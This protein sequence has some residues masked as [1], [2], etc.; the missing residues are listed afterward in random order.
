MALSATDSPFR[1]LH[2]PRELRDNVYEEIAAESDLRPYDENAIGAWWPASGRALG[3][4]NRQIRSELL[5]V[6]ILR[7]AIKF[8]MHFHKDL[9]PSTL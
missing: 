4:A 1:F 3:Q 9:R 5:R 7:N 8:S 6:L 2:L